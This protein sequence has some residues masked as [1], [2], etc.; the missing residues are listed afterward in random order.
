MSKIFT[1]TKKEL[2]TYFASPTAYIFLGTYLLITMFTFFWVEK[3]FSRNLADLRPL[4]DWLPVLLIFLI[5]TL[6]MKMWSEERRMGTIEFLLTLPVKTHH[7]VL[8]KFFACLSMV[9]TALLLTFGLAFSV[10][11]LGPVDWGP[12]FGAYLASLLLA[13]SYIAIGLY[14]SSKTQSQIVSLILTALICSALYIVGS[15]TLTNLFGNQISEIL[16]LLGVGSRFDSISRGVIDFRDIYYYLSITV[17]FLAAN[18]FSLQ[19]LKWSSESPKEHHRLAKAFIVLFIINVAG[20]NFWLD[21]VTSIRADLT[22]NRMYSISPATKEM[23]AQLQEP[24]LI[25]GYFSE[26]THPFLAP[27]VPTVRDFLQEYKSAGR[28]K[29]RSEFVDP[30]Q[31]EELE[32]ELKRKYGVEPAPFQISDRSSVSMVNSYFNIVIEYG[33]EFEVLSFDDLIEVKYDSV[34]NIDVQLRN[35]EYDITKAIKKTMNA[36]NSTD[37]F[38]ANLDHDIQFVAYVSHKDI[39]QELKTFYNDMKNVVSTY[40]KDSG[41]KLKVKYLDPSEDADLAKRIEEEYGFT[42]QSMGVFSSETFYFYLTLVDGEKIYSLGVPQDLSVDTFKLNMDAALKR[43]APGFLRNLAM[44]TPP[45]ANFNPMMAQMGMGPGGKRFEALKKKLEQ[46]YNVTSIDL[47]SGM[48]PSD[49]DVLLV[50]APKELEEKQVFAIDQFLMKGGSVI[51]ATS[52]VSV[53][54]QNRAFASERSVSGLE[55]WLG[56]Y[57]I[58]IPSELVLD[59]N[60][61]GFPSMRRRTVQGMTIQEPYIA[62]YPFFP[63]IRS[64]GMNAENAITS[65]LGQ[66]TFA[67]PSPILIDE[68]KNKERKVVHLL[69]SSENS[70]RSTDISIEPNPAY[71]MGF[72]EPEM[73]KI[74]PSTLAVLVEGRFESYFKGKKSP[75][76]EL[77]KGESSKDKED[78]GHEHNEGEAEEEK[79]PDNTVYSVLEKSPNV[80]RI[81]VFA[82]NDFA[83]DDATQILGMMGGTQYTNN[84]QLV[85]NAVDWSVMDRTLLSIRS[86]G[87][88]ARTLVPLTDSEKQGW[89]AFN[90]LFAL[91][92]LFLVWG[93]YKYT[94]RRSQKL[95]KT[96]NIVTGE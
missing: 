10:G 50:A 12:V 55:E 72:E 73:N 37:N 39:P 7:L 64:S 80:A 89:E 93:A 33:S 22:A 2:W 1:V 85:E 61:V 62:P 27:L 83:A 35:L 46:T 63:D 66:L 87:H 91:F 19:T 78:H 23:I 25:R 41:G 48:V 3:F 11:I 24:L 71:P 30:R 74:K 15:T 95:Y 84:L 51:L 59:R 38:F 53:E 82:S 45:Q 16:K 68:N 44:Y 21:K 86:R 36:F 4:F 29:I 96:L 49:I 77:A 31:S 13:S 47:N 90:Y 14:V 88:F 8:G 52:S 69:E 26:K 34:G 75:L 9:A 79:T 58:E 67:W 5:S 17:V 32:A 28:G 40:E 94:Q 81:V 54:R 42:P 43:T 92:G 56:N 65:G 20:A 60:N 76:V 70:W 6:T 57:G 18:T